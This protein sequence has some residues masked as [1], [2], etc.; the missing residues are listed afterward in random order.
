MSLNFK[1]G[2]DCVLI[3]IKEVFGCIAAPAF[4]DIDVSTLVYV[5]TS[6]VK[7]LVKSAKIH[8]YITSPKI[9]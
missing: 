2:L 9:I 6:F 4:S 8:S 3:Y 5:M 7:I 1:V